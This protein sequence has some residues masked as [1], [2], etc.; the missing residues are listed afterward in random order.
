MAEK[1]I[2]LLPFTTQEQVL[3]YLDGQ[4]QLGANKYPYFD[5]VADG[6]K[7]YGKFGEGLTPEVGERLI[8]MLGTIAQCSANG[9]L[10]RLD[11]RIPIN[12]A[13][14]GTGTLLFLEFWLTKGMSHDALADRLKTF[15]PPNHIRTP[16]EIEKTTQALLIK[17]GFGMEE[18]V[19]NSDFHKRLFDARVAKKTE[20]SFFNRRK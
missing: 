12:G 6:L 15:L 4:K 3:T 19:L 5:K 16:N 11:T 9:L 14:P 2:K 1:K 10:D 7:N 17:G 18:M 20:S 13:K 8:W